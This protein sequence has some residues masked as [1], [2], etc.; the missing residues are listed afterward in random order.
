VRRRI[1]LIATAAALFVAPAPICA[2][3]CLEAPGAQSTAASAT[4]HPCHDAGGERAPSESPSAP[5]ACGCG[6]AHEALVSATNVA[7]ATP[8]AIAP[9]SALVDALYASADWTRAVPR[10][11][12]LPPPDL[13][14]LE[15]IL[16]L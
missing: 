16:L 11:T 3:A 12:D 4:E 9:P 8:L 14:L 13:L 7:P 1:W 6:F 2:I 10:D 5:E 15:S